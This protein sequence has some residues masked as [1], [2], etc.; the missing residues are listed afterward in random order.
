MHDLGKEYSFEG[1][2]MGGV[3]KEILTEMGRFNKRINKEVERLEKSAS[4]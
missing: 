2:K 4:E 1:N 3:V